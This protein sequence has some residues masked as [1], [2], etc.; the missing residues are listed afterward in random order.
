VDLDDLKRALRLQ[1]RDRLTFLVHA[2]T[3]EGDHDI[4]GKVNV[5]DVVRGRFESAAVGYDAYDPYAGRGLFAEGLRLVLNL[6]FTP[7]D[8]GG[9]G[10]HRVQAAV[11]PGNVRSAGLLRSLGFQR[12][13]F[14]PRMLWLP[15]A[16]GVEAWRD[17]HCYVVIADE[18][19]AQPYPPA[20]GRQ[21]VALVNGAP[22]SGAGTLARQLAEELRVPLFSHEVAGSGEALWGLLADSPVGGVVEGFA[23]GDVRG[24]TQGLSQCGLDPAGVCEVWC[25]SAQVE[26]S[27]R[28]LGL[29]PTVPVDMGHGLARAEVVRI[30]LQ[31]A[32]GLAPA[33][34]GSR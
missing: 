23:P 25:F 28:P 1:S 24:V 13:G 19:P 32:A 12:E 10:L 9:V 4:V 11:Q 22:G 17:H 30:A 8:G 33:A 29:G 16:D 26:A 27:A 14:S 15:G 2:L 34:H 6:L 3:P 7:E 18:W 5:S 20:G 21:V 31:V